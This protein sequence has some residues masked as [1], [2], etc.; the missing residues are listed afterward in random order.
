MFPAVLPDKLYVLVIRLCHTS[1]VWFCMQ[2]AFA[3]LSSSSGVARCLVDNLGSLVP[4]SPLGTRCLA[5]SPH[6][7]GRGHFSASQ[8]GLS[9]LCSVGCAMADFKENHYPKATAGLLQLYCS[10][11]AS[12]SFDRGY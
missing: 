10:L 6:A 2:H 9:F 7:C 8:R 5:P 12:L 3:K 1:D 4:S 11:C